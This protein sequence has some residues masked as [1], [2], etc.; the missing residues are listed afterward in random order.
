MRVSRASPLP[1]SGDRSNAV[2]VMVIVRL[3]LGQNHRLRGWQAVKA[4][5]AKIE[6][7]PDPCPVSA[8]SCRCGGSF[9]SPISGLPLY[10]RPVALA[11]TTRRA[12]GMRAG[13]PVTCRPAAGGGARIQRLRPTVMLDGRWSY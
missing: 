8:L 12:A 6:E 7:D 10:H 13:R 2:M 5:S 1:P 3:L 11:L 4:N 9:H